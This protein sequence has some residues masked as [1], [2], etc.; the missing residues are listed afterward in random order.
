[1]LIIAVV[2]VGATLFGLAV[3]A[4][5][6]VGPVVLELTSRHGV[7]FGDIVAFVG[8]YIVAL[9]VTLVVLAFW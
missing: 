3:A 4:T 9:L 8:S 7:H 5:T 2:W 6:T 1:M